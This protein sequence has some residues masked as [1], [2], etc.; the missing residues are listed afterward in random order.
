MRAFV[1]SALN[2]G[3]SWLIRYLQG[4]ST[5]MSPGK[6]KGGKFPSDGFCLDMEEQGGQLRNI[7]RIFFL[8]KITYLIHYI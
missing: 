3:C 4:A 6:G 7:E 5:D 8:K 1:L 2:C